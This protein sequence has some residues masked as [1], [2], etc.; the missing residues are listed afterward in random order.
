MTSTPQNDASDKLGLSDS[1]PS[2]SG[3][4]VETS[5]L[6]ATVLNPGA[7]RSSKVATP[8]ADIPQQFGRYRI[9]KEL[10]RGGMGAVFLAHDVQLQRSVALK[11]P[12]FRDDDEGDAVERFYREARTMAVLQHANLCPVFDVGQFEQWHFLTMA[13]ID[14]Q[15]LSHTLKESGAMPLTAALTLMK[16]VALGRAEGA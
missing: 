13:F 15:P 9:E 11:I 7:A 1:A 12:F 2:G 16:T 5:Q 4:K 6:D 14:G 10:G 8:L 3:P